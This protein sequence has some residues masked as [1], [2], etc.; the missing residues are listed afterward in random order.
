VRILL[1][2][3][4]LI[5]VITQGSGSSGQASA[6]EVTA[7]CVGLCEKAA[8]CRADAGLEVG[9]D[10]R[11][12]EAACGRSG[13]YAA[14]PFAAWSCV[15]EICG[16]PFLACTAQ[17]VEWLTESTADGGVLIAPIDYPSGL[18]FLSGG[19]PQAS[20][21][22]PGHFLIAYRAPA[23]DVGAAFRIELSRTQWSIEGND[24]ELTVSRGAQTIAIQL[25]EVEDQSFMDITVQ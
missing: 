18:P 13:S 8:S 6:E 20:P 2:C 11:D 1:T 24:T 5:A 22:S 15:S 16:E 23:A 21:P 12:C 17:A 10:E 3:L 9:S 25:L 14:M 19:A 4:S 7:D